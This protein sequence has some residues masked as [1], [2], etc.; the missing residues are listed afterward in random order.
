MQNGK[1]N[2]NETYEVIMKKRYRQL[3]AK[4]NQLRSAYAKEP[5]ESPDLCY[6]WGEGCSKAD[7]HLLH[8]VFSLKRFLPNSFESDMSFID[9]LEKRGYD[10]KTFKFSIEKR[11]DEKKTKQN[12][13][14]RQQRK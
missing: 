5:F 10:I 12:N 11:I 14:A 3:K 6:A 1:R 13:N 9:E 7:A 2:I 4:P 8:N